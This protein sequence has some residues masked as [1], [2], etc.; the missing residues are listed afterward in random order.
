MPKLLSGAWN[1][2]QRERI[3]RIRRRFRPEYPQ[4]R[5]QPG[6]EWLQNQTPCLGLQLR[7]DFESLSSRRKCF[8]LKWR[9]RERRGKS[10]LG[11]NVVKRGYKIRQQ[12][13]S[14]RILLVQ[15]SAP[16][17]VPIRRLAAT[18]PCQ[19]NCGP[20]LARRIFTSGDVD[21]TEERA[22]FHR[23]KSREENLYN[24][25]GIM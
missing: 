6:K 3:W 23:P 12:S 13:A 21:M 18:Q 11:V 17:K 1:E 24:Q 19:N 7:Q 14:F 16:S 25:Q 4:C 9:K 20:S 22:R 2:K 8:N 10:Y 5:C 15:H